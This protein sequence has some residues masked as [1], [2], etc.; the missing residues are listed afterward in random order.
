MSSRS[1]LVVGSANIDLVFKTPQFPSPGE[2]LLGRSFA[3]YP[4]GKGANQA[5]AAA[6]LDGDVSFVGCVGSDPFGRILLD[7]LQEAGVNCNWVR[8]L[9]DSA[10]GAANIL[11]NDRGQN[12]IVVAPG[13]NWKLTPGDVREALA[14][15]EDSV[16][17]CQLE[18]P[19]EAVAEASRSKNFILNPA[20]ARNLSDDIL[21][22]CLAITPNQSETAFLTGI[23]PSN[24]ESCRSAAA[25]FL[26]KGVR[27]VVLTL[28]EGGS[29]WRSADDEAWIPALTVTAV[30][31]VAAGDA[32][33]GALALRYAQTGDWKESLRI[34]TRVAAISV[35]RVG[36]QSSMPTLA[37]L[38][39]FERGHP[40]RHPPGS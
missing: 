11:V 2:T 10:T 38:I 1:V 8:R 36:A 16:V 21:S 18:I 26:G 37:E 12:Q 34:A 13:A 31:T 27:N 19:E 22:R 30:D 14:S 5:V 39:D 35:T 23:E 6:K 25:F 3:S 9:E 17:L 32:F 40:D 15:H 4:G 28:G 29:Y 20:P 7:S 24:T 33:S